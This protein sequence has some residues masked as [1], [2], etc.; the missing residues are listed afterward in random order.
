MS[1]SEDLLNL[2]NS[3]RNSEGVMVCVHWTSGDESVVFSFRAYV[4]EADADGI[5]FATDED[6]G[7]VSMTVSLEGSKVTHM[8]RREVCVTLR[9]GAKLVMSALLQ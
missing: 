4:F 3:W 2:L 8:D 7:N 6:K 5:H 1:S 9:S